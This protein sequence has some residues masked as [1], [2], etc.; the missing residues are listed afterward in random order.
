MVAA[1]RHVLREMGLDSPKV[2]RP[3]PIGAIAERLT[4]ITGLLAGVQR[5]RYRGFRQHAGPLLDPGRRSLQDR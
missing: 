4:C 2:A 3:A 1:I 5:E